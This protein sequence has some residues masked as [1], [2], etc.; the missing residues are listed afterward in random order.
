MAAPG[1]PGFRGGARARA[2]SGET[3]RSPHNGQPGPGLVPCGHGHEPV[4]T[5]HREKAVDTAPG[6]V[7]L[8]RGP[9][10]RPGGRGPRRQGGRRPGPHPRGHD[11]RLLHP[12]TSW[13]RTA[14]RAATRPRPATSPPS[15]PPPHSSAWS[16]PRASAAARTTPPDGPGGAR[17]RPQAPGHV[18][19]VNRQPRAAALPGRPLPFP[20]PAEHPAPIRCTRIPARRDAKLQ[21]TATGKSPDRSAAHQR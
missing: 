12:T 15:S 21:L 18:H 4:F 11:G 13:T 16:R 8:R 17:G 14:T 20:G 5:G 1:R 6:P 9:R 2:S 7:A 19:R 10:H 3:F